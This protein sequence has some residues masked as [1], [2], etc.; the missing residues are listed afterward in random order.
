MQENVDK[1]IG[2]MQNQLTETQT[3]VKQLKSELI[4]SLSKL[5]KEEF[6]QK[7]AWGNGSKEP[8]TTFEKMKFESLH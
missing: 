7:Q 8:I 3:Q 2:E 1:K 4:E 5:I 6:G